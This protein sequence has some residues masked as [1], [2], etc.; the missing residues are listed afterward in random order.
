MS[1]KALRDTCIHTV[2]VSLTH[3]A[4][5]ATIVTL[6]PYDLKKPKGYITKPKPCL[7][8]ERITT[9]RADYTMAGAY[10]HQLLYVQ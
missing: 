7:S 3:C 5:Q 6:R 1:L 10:E 4:R 9:T 2:C 8:S